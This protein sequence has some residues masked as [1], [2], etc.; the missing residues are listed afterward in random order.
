M[1][2]SRD[3]G[4]IILEAGLS[5]WSGRPACNQIPLPVAIQLP[6]PKH[7]RQRRTQFT[8]EPLVLCDAEL[9]DLA[10]DPFALVP[11]QFADIGLMPSRNVA[12]HGSFLE[13]W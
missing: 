2:I 10:L 11:E 1:F 6:V 5:C 13:S 3:Q 12:F 9:G 8:F 4:Q 7:C